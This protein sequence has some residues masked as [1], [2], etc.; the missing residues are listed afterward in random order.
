MWPADTAA[1]PYVL[2]L[3]HFGASLKDYPNLAK[4]SET[5][6]VGCSVTL[7]TVGRGACHHLVSVHL[8]ATSAKF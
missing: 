7:A 8:T 5:I 4:Y 3:K 2:A 1:G 6:G